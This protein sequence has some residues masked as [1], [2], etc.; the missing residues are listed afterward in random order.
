MVEC[1]RLAKQVKKRSIK[2]RHPDIGDNQDD[3]DRDKN[4]IYPYIIHIIHFCH[5]SSPLRFAQDDIVKYNK[6]T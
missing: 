1:Y 2:D 6:Y 3:Y 4:L 5:P